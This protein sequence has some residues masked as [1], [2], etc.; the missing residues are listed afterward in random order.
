MTMKTMMMTITVN[1]RPGVAC[2]AKL[3]RSAWRAGKVDTAV[4]P[5][6]ECE[7]PYR[8][9]Q[10]LGAVSSALPTYKVGGQPASP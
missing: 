1:H 2:D 7:I 8:R 9:V 4:Y 10:E 5:E 6:P 3:V